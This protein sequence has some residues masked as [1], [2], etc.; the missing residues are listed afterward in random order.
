MINANQLSKTIEIHTCY[1]SIDLPRDYR[2]KNSNFLF[3]I[4][5]LGLIFKK[6]IIINVSRE[7]NVERR[8]LTLFYFSIVVGLFLFR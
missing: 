6:I 5:I 1:Y 7:L 2:W 4:T 3:F 8:C